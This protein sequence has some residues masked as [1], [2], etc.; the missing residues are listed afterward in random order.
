ML[1]GDNL[2]TIYLHDAEEGIDLA[3]TF[4]YAKQY[5]LIML[6]GL[7]PFS[8]EQAYSSTLREGELATPPMVAGV[9]A[10]ITNTLLNYLLI[11]GIGCF[12]KMG[13]QGAAIAT[14][15]SRF[16]QVIIVVAWTH[17]NHKKLPF[18]CRLYR[19]F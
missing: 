13:V 3:A 16:V 12:P 7:V 2:I 14:V 5:L 11:F 9:V 17:A 6:I 18:V 8:L 19:S 1:L 15:I 10:V 4:E